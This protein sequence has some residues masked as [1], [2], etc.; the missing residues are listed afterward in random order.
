MLITKNIRKSSRISDSI[1]LTDKIAQYDRAAKNILA[2]KQILARILKECVSELQNFSIEQIINESLTGNIEIGTVPID[3]DVP[4]LLNSEDVSV[5]EGIVRFDILLWVKIPGKE[6]EL[7]ILL[8]LEAQKKEPD[9][10]PVAKRGIYYGGRMLSAQKDVSFSGSDYGNLRKVYS[11]WIIMNSVK[12]REDSMIS[13]GIE[14]EVISGSYSEETENYDLLKLII[15]RLGR[16]EDNEED[17]PLIGMLK[18]LFSKEK[19]VKTKKEK[20][21]NDFGIKMSKGSIEEV[22]V[23]C[24]LGE[25]LYEE[26]YEKA[27][28][29]AYG[30]AYEEAREKTQEELK[31]LEIAELY[32]AGKIDRDTA[33]EFMRVSED[34]FEQKIKKVKEKMAESVK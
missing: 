5:K 24:N 21:E 23:M 8:N 20:L 3:R 14:Q 31:G 30:E 12:E 17:I 27:Y 34:V 6:D 29:E 11:I 33:F 9:K 32:L 4:E 16:D 19:N 1:D 2:D 15:I 7:G 13:F 10:Y 28:G 26:A 18:T 25:G 22:N